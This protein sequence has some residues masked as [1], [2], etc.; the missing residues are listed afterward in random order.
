MICTSIHKMKND[1]IIKQANRPRDATRKFSG[2]R[3]Q[4]ERLDADKDDWVSSIISNRP[5]EI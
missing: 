4:N 5:K 1:L 2:S 3:A